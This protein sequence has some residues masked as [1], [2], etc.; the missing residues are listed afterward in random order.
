MIMK[1]IAYFVIAAF[2]L[3]GCAKVITTTSN[4]TQLTIFDAWVW[5]NHPDS[6]NEGHLGGYI[7]KDTELT[8]GGE[9][10]GDKAFIFA[11]CTVRDLDGNVLST[12]E[13]DVMKQLGT[14]SPYDYHGPYV[15]K[16]DSTNI[17]KSLRD[18]LRPS[19]DIVVGPKAKAEVLRR[20]V[21]RDAAV[22]GFLQSANVYSTLEEYFRTVTEG[23]SSQYSITLCDATNDI[24]AWQIDTMERS[25]IYKKLAHVSSTDS[26][27]YG[28]YYE[29]IDFDPKDTVAFSKDTTINIYY[30]GRLL[31]GYVFDTNIA[32][33]AKVHNL[34]KSGSSYTPMKIKYVEEWEKI[35]T[36]SNSSETSDL[37]A[38]FRKII[39][40]MGQRRIGSAVGMFYSDLAYGA[41]SSTGKYPAFSPMIFEITIDPTVS[42]N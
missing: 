39:Y 38:G 22:P 16:N 34:Y 40:N 27:S 35:G 29:P 1:K 13:P 7:L 23:V 31:N 25:R 26:T 41:N 12:N 28:F 9:T 5:K 15:W 30:V 4:N 20:G 36:S 37:I 24:T 32:D 10:A 19:G 6:Y 18:I 14:Y 42:S 3:V 8:T 2:A 11:Y 17:Y 33:T 21:R